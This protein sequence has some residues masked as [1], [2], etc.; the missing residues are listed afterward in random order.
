LIAMRLENASLPKTPATASDLKKMRAAGKATG[1]P[2]I[3]ESPWFN[4]PTLKVEGQ[5]LIC[6]R[7]AG[8]YVVVCPLAEKELLI[9]MD[10]EV[11]FD[12]DHHAGYGAV[13]AWADKISAKD[14]A[15]RIAR[16]W[17]VQALKALQRKVDGGTPAK[18]AK[19]KRKAKA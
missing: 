13:L 6:A 14:L 15:D 12:T 8:V 9:D 5:W 18:A 7:Q 3:E 19:P 1:L 2:G 17:R 16:A 11:Y 10:P 4:R